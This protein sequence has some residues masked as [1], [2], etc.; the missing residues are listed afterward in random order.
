M[1]VLHRY[2][3]KKEYYILTRL[4]GAVVTFQVTPEGRS[5]L[6]A[7]GVEE[8]RQFGRSL[9]LE[10][11]KS[12]D[13][14][15]RASMPDIDLSGWVQAA[16]DFSDDPVPES[17]V[18]I[19]ADCG[20]P[21]GLHLV[22]V[23]EKGSASFLSIHC[24]DCCTQQ[25]QQIGICV[26]TA[27]LTRPF[28]RRIMGLCGVEELDASASAYLEMLEHSYLER[29]SRS[30]PSPKHVQAPLFGSAHNGQGKLL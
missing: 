26:P 27:A 30:K 12:G 29:L 9:L 21:Y 10:L 1:P 14:Y 17:S 5:K 18:P 24:E 13:A 22:S 2:K 25:R 23:L 7:I 16:L 28:M 4:N 11:C 6:A 8:G 15:T 20:S 3:A 19:C